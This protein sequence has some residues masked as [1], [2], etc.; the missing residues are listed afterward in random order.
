[1]R[2]VKEDTVFTPEGNEGEGSKERQRRTGNEKKINY[3]VE[4][5]RHPGWRKQ[6]V[7]KMRRK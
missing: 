3:G 5:K 1:M 6:E 2:R 7:R 4:R